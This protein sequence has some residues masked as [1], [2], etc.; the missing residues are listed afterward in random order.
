M[1]PALSCLLGAG[2]VCSPWVCSRRCS[3]LLAQR[4]GGRAGCGCRCRRCRRRACCFERC[5][6]RVPTTL[7]FLPGRAPTRPLRPALLS[8]QVK[9][10]TVPGYAKGLADGLP[11]FVAQASWGAGGGRRRVLAG[12]RTRAPAACCR[13]QELRCTAAHVAAGGGAPPPPPPACPLL[14]LRC[15]APAVLALCRRVWAACSRA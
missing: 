8:P 9:V 2:S 10:Q 15:F 13:H 6:E 14:T 4:C 12:L 7:H 11:K 3:C 1:V 5:S